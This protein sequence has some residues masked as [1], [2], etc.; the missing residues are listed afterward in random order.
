MHKLIPTL[1]TFSLCLCVSTGISS[2]Y[3]G[4]IQVPAQLE[5]TLTHNV[6]LAKGK[7]KH[8]RRGKSTSACGH[9]ANKAACSRGKRGR[10]RGNS[11]GFGFTP[12]GHHKGWDKGRGNP[13]R[14]W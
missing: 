12:P 13:H 2:A 11:E 4:V 3:A 14:G 9:D 8:A 5:S 1:A 10:A 6:E 7:P